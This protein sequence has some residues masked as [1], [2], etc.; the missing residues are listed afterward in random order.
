M[1]RVGQE[2]QEVGEVVD[3]EEVGAGG[4]GGEGGQGEEG[5]GEGWWGGE[6]GDGGGK[7]GE[8]ELDVACLLDILQLSGIPS[9]LLF[10]YPLTLIIG[11]LPIRLTHHGHPLVPHQAAH[12]HTQGHSTHTCRP[13]LP[14]LFQQERIIPI[15]I[16][17]LLPVSPHL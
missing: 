1:E 2:G 12:G 14:Q 9:I 4:D 8:R 15:L 3:V 13:L 6:G 16:L 17:D 11:R 10:R 5:K 7:G